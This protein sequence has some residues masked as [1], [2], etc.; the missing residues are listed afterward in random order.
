MGVMGPPGL[1]S[2]GSRVLEN[3]NEMKRNETKMR[4]LKLRD[5]IKF[6]AVHCF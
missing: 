2:L 1:G 3:P 4:K 6:T 5:S